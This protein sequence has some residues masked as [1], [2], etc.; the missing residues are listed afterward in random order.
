MA[1]SGRNV[2]GNDFW[3]P[4]LNRGTSIWAGDLF[5]GLIARA[6]EL[7]SEGF[8]AAARE[9]NA[10]LSPLGD[11]EA[12]A[13]LGDLDE[14]CDLVLFY[15]LTVRERIEMEP[16]MAILPVPVARRFVERE[17][18][19]QL[20]PSGAGFHE[21][22]SV[23]AVGRPFRWRPFFRR[24]GSIND[25]KSHPATFLQHA[26]FREALQP[27]PLPPSVHRALHAA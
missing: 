3:M 9:L 16:R 18:V 2:G 24:T 7:P 8:R 13:L 23:G 5:A 14:G 15:G 17:M 22:R 1:V 6:P 26:L 25:P 27:H 12:A 11:D 19:E 4:I 20:A 21:W 10:L